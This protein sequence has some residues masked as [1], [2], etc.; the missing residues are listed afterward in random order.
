[1]A[2]AKPTALAYR[3]PIYKRLLNIQEIGV[4]IGVAV[5]FTVFVLIDKNMGQIGNLQLMSLEGSLIGLAAFGMSFL[6]V[7]GEIDLSAGATAGLAAVVAGMLRAYL[8]W[9]ELACIASAVAVGALVGLFNSLIVLRFGMPAFFATLGA[10][11]LL[12]GLSIWLVQ[13]T[14]IYTRD[15]TPL[16]LSVMAPSPIFGLPWLFIVLL[17]TYIIGDL[18][19]RFT[20]LGPI[21]M[22]VGGNRQAAAIVGINVPLV[23]ILCFMFVGV[24]AA[25]AG[26]A[27]MGYAGTA[28]PTIGIDWMLWIIAIAI[29]G[30]GSLRGGVGSIIGAFLGTCLVEI[31]RTGL[32]DAHVQTNAQGIVIGGVLIG[33]AILDAVRRKSAQY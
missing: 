12:S 10:S 4:L 6:M 26:L 30:G 16:L 7:A 19:M 29:I 21:L 3:P 8:G 9:P 11:F 25:L 32:F 18:L 33:A 31:I 1:M 23:K 27:V 17:P 15:M 20:V 22:S 14:W 2:I 13:G 5:F 24:C 28:D